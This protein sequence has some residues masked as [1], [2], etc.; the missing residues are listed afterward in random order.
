VAANA[1]A[2]LASIGADWA[3][4]ETN[5]RGRD[6]LIT[7]TPPDQAAINIAKER[8][9]SSYGVNIVDISSDVT[10]PIIP[11]RPAKLKVTIKGE[12]VALNGELANQTSI[13]QVVS[14]AENAFGK[15][16]VSNKL[17]IGSNI[18]A[19]PDIEGFFLNLAGKSFGLESLI[20]S[21][22]GRS[23]TLKGSV[24]S[25]N[26][27]SL[28]TTQMASSQ[29]FEVEN[30]VT[31]AASVVCQNSVTELL[32][33][34]KI[35]FESGKATIQKT[36]YTLLDNIKAAAS[37]CPE[38]R[39]EVSGHT[40]SVGSLNFNMTLSEQRAQAVVNH[41]VGL[42]LSASKFV[43]TGHGPNKP[44]AD[45]E[46]RDGRAQNRRIEFKLKN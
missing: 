38:T 33:N 14:Q 6:V 31:V 36:S 29:A 35:N 27:L 40:D 9:E 7:G 41:L 13:D 28:L 10:A 18:G 46:T 20:A 4:V 1:R 24:N 8:V 15:G 22:N 5:N 19:L 23:L 12:S 25:E 39:F 43:A 11:V 42:G 2:D 17:R 37:T 45:N 21:L 3:N 16:N 30:K 26:S 44:I 34:S 32:N